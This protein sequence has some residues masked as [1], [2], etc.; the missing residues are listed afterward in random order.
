MPEVGEFR[1]NNTTQ[2][3]AAS[4]AGRARRGHIGCR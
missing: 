3:V 4:R 1:P 2:P